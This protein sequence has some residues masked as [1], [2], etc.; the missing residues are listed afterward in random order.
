VLFWLI[1][2]KFGCHGNSRDFLEKLD[3]IFEFADPKNPT[4]G[5]K[6]CVD[7]LYRSEVM[8]IRL[9]RV[10]T[11]AGIGSFRDFCEK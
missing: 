9:F 5:A 6:N 2:S 10:T 3:I 1:L 11:I 7:T 8:V 4:I